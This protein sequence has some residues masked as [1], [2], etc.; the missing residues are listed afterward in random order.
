M[1]TNYKPTFDRVLI[2]W[3]D[4]V[5]DSQTWCSLEEALDKHSASCYT[6]GYLIKDVPS[7]ITLAGT[8]SMAYDDE[9]I[10]QFMII[11]RGCID[12][13][14]RLT[15]GEAYAQPQETQ[16]IPTRF[17]HYPEP[18]TR[19]STSRDDTTQYNTHTGRYP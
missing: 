7:A 12:S 6:I 3:Y 9:A 8:L 1:A 15:E 4:T 10:G 18:T 5:G 19:H 13:I 11:P 17:E 16:A 2:H 14:I